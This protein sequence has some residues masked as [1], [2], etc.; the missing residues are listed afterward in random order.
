MLVVVSYVGLLGLCIYVLL[1]NG[2]S[3][4]SLAAKLATLGMT[5]LFTALVSSFAGL[6]IGAN[7]K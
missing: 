1:T 2:L 5:A 6:M 4:D 7:R 3:T